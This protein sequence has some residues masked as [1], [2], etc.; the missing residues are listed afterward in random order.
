MATLSELVNIVARLEALD[1]RSVALLARYLREAGLITKRGRGLSAASM[2]VVDAANL[3][4]AVNATKNVADAAKTVQTY[5][6]LRPEQHE[7]PIDE[8][9]RDFT[10]GEAVEQ[11]LMAT[12]SGELPR[13]FL[14]GN[15]D[16]DIELVEMF[17]GEKV[18]VELRFRTNTPAAF[19]RVARP[20]DLVTSPELTTRLPAKVW[21]H[22]SSR[23]GRDPP[24]TLQHPSGDR[25]E[26]ITIGFTTLSAVGKLIRSQA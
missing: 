19:L 9:S 4:I 16:G 15:R 21:L 25:V 14:G 26:E 10:L 1:P 2:S 23:K 13:P 11:L 6:R 3:L 24:G 17:A 22:F 7:P 20:F 12:G 5:R 18:A 8:W